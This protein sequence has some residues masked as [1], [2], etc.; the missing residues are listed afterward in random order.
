MASLNLGQDVANKSERK[1]DSCS[2]CGQILSPIASCY[3]S[4]IIINPSGIIQQTAIGYGQ[5]ISAKDEHLLLN[6]SYSTTV[7]YECN[8]LTTHAM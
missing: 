5:I 8:Y 7:A 2:Y 1:I 6:M 3:G 4:L